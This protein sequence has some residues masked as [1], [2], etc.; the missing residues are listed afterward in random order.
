MLT[1]RIAVLLLCLCTP[2]SA[3]ITPNPA[4][5]A[6]VVQPEAQPPAAFAHLRADME[7]RA[8]QLRESQLTVRRT[9]L[10]MLSPAQRELVATMIGQLA[11]AP[12][13]D[14]AV[15]TQRIDAALSPTQ[16]QAVLH[17]VA[18]EE[19]QREAIFADM[20]AQ[21][22]REMAVQMPPLASQVPPD[23]GSPHSPAIV[24]QAG[25]AIAMSGPGMPFAIAPGQSAGLTLLL[26][27]TSPGS[28]P[29]QPAPVMIHS[30]LVPTPG[31]G[32]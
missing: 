30:T 26:M 28:S 24:F 16:R 4:P 8:A 25:S 31:S 21:S 6:A 32:P 18:A 12:E 20:V 22:Q 19:S 2:A 5:S 29:F 9:V 13:P 14:I 23:A 27:L 3:E 17:L 11:I 7:R 1:G 15:A 10:G